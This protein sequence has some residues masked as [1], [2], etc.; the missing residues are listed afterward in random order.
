MK[1]INGRGQLGKALKKYL[2]LYKHVDCIIY[3]TWNMIDKSEEG[4]RQSCLDFM[5]FVR[6]NDKKK[7]VFISTTHPIHCHYMEYKNLSEIFLWNYTNDGVVIRL[8]SLIGKGKIYDKCKKGIKLKNGYINIDTIDNA[9]K[10]ILSLV[11]SK[12]RLNVINGEKVHSDIIQELINV[13]RK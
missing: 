8:P 3:H 13:G 12:E 1:L 10:T 7:I 9:A 2:K 4:Q 6:K 5:K 11:D